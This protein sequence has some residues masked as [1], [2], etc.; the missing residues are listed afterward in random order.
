MGSRRS[1]RRLRRAAFP[2][3]L[4][5]MVSVLLAAPAGAERQIDIGFADH[6]F[7]EGER[8][9]WLNRAEGVKADIIRVNMYWSLVALAE[10]ESPRDPADPFYDWSVIDRQV[11]AAKDHGFD[12]EL[13]VTAAPPFAQGPNRPPIGDRA[14]AGSWKPDAA[15]YGDFVRAVAKRY[16]G[17][18]EAGGRTLPRIDYFEAWNEPNLHTY[19]TPQYRGRENVSADIYVRLLNAA[20]EAVKSVDPTMKV[21]T[22]GTAPYGDPP[23]GKALKTR[24]LAFYRDLLC[25]TKKLRRGPCAGGQEAKFDILAHHPINREDPPTAH[26]RN[27]DDVEVADFGELGKML[28]RAER[29]GTTGTPGR[30]GLWAN[31]VWWQTNPPDRGEG[32]SLKTHARWTQQAIYLL[33]KQGASNVTF[34]QFRDARYR[35]GEFTLESYQTGIYT[36]REQRKPSAT[37]VAFPFVT[38]RRGKRDLLAWG[39]APKSGRLTIE[40]RRKGGFRR[41]SSFRVEAGEVFTK[42]LRLRGGQDLRAK[43]GGARSLI[44]EGRG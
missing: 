6:L 35:P 29:L 37:A 31:E 23:S 10:P 24:P 11:T 41:A 22:G 17:T 38:D 15:K 40:V 3:L 2:L 4:A 28:R 36:F 18:F 26:A 39:R 5:G 30:H 12:V 8:D 34:L 19:I 16:S 27:D 20:Y 33:W 1:P 9:K 7:G 25:L 42:S 14:P 13:T 43:V 21:V 44:W 32:V